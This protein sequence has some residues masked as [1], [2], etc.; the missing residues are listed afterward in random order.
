ME[1]IVKRTLILASLLLLSSFVAFPQTNAEYVILRMNT[2]TI[3]INGESKHVGDT[4]YDLDLI[5]WVDRKPAQSIEIEDRTD[6]NHTRYTITK[7]LLAS[8]S[9]RRISDY[10]VATKMSS[11]GLFSTQIPGISQES[12][13]RKLAIVIGNSHYLYQPYLNNAVLDANIIADR[14]V[15]LGFDTQIAFDCKAGELEKLISSISTR[16]DSYDVVLFYFAGHGIS[17]NHVP[18][19]VPIDY[20]FGGKLLDVSDLLIKLSSDKLAIVLLDMCRSDY[21]ASFSTG[22]QVETPPGSNMVVVYSTSDGRNAYDGELDSSP[23]TKGLI[24]ALEDKQLSMLECF[25]AATGYV[26]EETNGLQCPT[27]S[28]SVHQYYSFHNQASFQLINSSSNGY[29][30][31]IAEADDYLEGLNGKEKDPEKAFSLYSIASASGNRVATIQLALCYFAGIGTEVNEAEGVR[32]LHHLVEKNDVEAMFALGLGLCVNNKTEEGEYWCE[33]AANMGDSYLQGCLGALYLDGDTIPRDDEKALAWLMRAAA[34]GNNI[35]KARLGNYYY[36]GKGGFYDYNKALLWYT[37]PA[38]EGMAIAQHQI[39]TIY[40]MG[41]GVEKDA[42]KALYW[43]KKAADQGLNFAQYNLATLYA[44]GE[45]TEINLNLARY[46][47]E[48][49]AVQG[50]SNAQV[51]LAKMYYNGKDVQKDYETALNWLFKA[52]DLNDSEAQFLI[53]FM[54]SEG[55]GVSLDMERSFYWCKL[56]AENDHI[57]AQLELSEKYIGGKGVAPNNELALYWL[58]KAANAGD[59]IAQNNLGTHYYYGDIVKQD[60]EQAI[61][62]HKMAAEQGNAEAMCN[63][64]LYYYYGEGVLKDY[65]IAFALLSESANQGYALAQYHLGESYAMGRGTMIN[66]QKAIEWY[67][68]AAIQGEERAIEAIN[69][70]ESK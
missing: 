45:G 26:K 21:S 18:Q 23:F 68:K 35:A 19:I 54:Y 15:E 5:E 47:Y 27:I 11:R 58:T 39:G 70:I 17:I 51:A 46:W 62:W 67:Q 12:F 13:E 43:Y 3:T 14:F 33:K 44:N 22:F 64:A 50:N 6:K 41:R 4:F 60:Y 8:K 31:I 20:N 28:S 56:A 55:T 36:Y 49:A 9:S 66:E 2:P 10:I 38:N 29:D 30:L 42:K 52:A 34:D 53:S 57:D 1:Q 7:K 61:Y 48:Q 25:S 37:D 40:G 59:V 32:L 16:K 24:K 65:D 69:L 63:Y